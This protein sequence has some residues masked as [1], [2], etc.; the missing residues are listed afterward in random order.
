MNIDIEKFKKDKAYYRFNSS[1]RR[2]KKKLVEYKGGKCEICGYD[3]CIAALDFHHLNPNEKDYSICNGD[4]KSFEK[5]K[6][7]HINNRTFNIFLKNNGL[8]YTKRKIATYHPTKEELIDLLK[9]NSKSAIG[10]MFGVSCGAVI[11]WCKK[12]EI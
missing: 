12:Y 4:Y 1:R 2:L 10:R 5:V 3:K 8:T 7:Y 6:K 11:K 9:K